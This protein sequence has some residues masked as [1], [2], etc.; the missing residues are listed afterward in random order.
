MTTPSTMTFRLFAVAAL[1]GLLAGP[2]GAEPPG[3]AAARQVVV[4]GKAAGGYAAFPDV[5]RTKKGDLFC[6]FY[7]GYGH[8]SKP[9]KDW[10]KGGRVMAVRSSDNGKTWGEPFVLA[11]TVH[12]DRDPSVA[13]LND[14][15]LLCNWFV[16]AN[17]D[18]P[19]PGNRPHAIFLSRSTDDGK[20]WG[21]PAELKVDS[22]DWFACSAPV[23]ELP[24]K[25]LILGL[26]TEN[27][28]G[29]IAYGATIRSDDG[30][31]T[32]KDLA[33]IGDKAGLYLDAETDVV[34][35]KDGTLLAALRSS[36]TDLHFATSA[37]G[38]KS[39]GK[40]YS[41]GFKGHCPHFL[42][43]SSG[44]ILLSHRLPATAVHWSFDEGKTW[45]GPL[46]IDTV[47]GAYP[48]C[49]ELPDGAVYCV[50][51]EEGAGSSIR[52]TRLKVSRS[53]V[54]AADER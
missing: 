47:S 42:R 13:V 23:R 20:T 3:P 46:Q 39:W 8:V 33:L 48:S 26:Y 49:V 2:A 10:P 25:S 37:D 40:V 36:K 38:G 44:A 12:D 17:P 34:R 43:H 5:C 7:S 51:Y 16:A 6:V 50:Y 45:Q 14:G 27:E 29:K 30:G 28:K 53:G 18:K 41:S 31:K 4:S 32:W 9:N 52:G 24:D 35:L 11:D 22:T 19:L 1:A 21:E 54:T 15:T